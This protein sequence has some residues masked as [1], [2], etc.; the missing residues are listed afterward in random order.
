MRKCSLTNQIFNN[1]FE[2][3]VVEAFSFEGTRNI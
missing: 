2:A 3:L 1:S